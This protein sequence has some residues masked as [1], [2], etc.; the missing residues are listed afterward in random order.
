MTAKMNNVPD[1]LLRKRDAADRLACSLRTVEREANEGRLTR[2][3][4]RGG[5]RFRESEI[6][7]IING[8]KS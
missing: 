7:R 6:L 3:K 2:I 5:V 4:V 1:K 8:G